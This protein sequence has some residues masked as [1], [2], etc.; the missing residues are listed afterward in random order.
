[1]ALLSSTKKKIAFILLLPF[2]ACLGLI[3]TLLSPVGTYVFQWLANNYVEELTIE[4]ISGSVLSGLSVEGIRYTGTPELSLAKAEIAINWQSTHLKQVTLSNIVLKQGEIRLPASTDTIETNEVEQP[5]REQA[6]FTSPVPIEIESIAVS[7]FSVVQPTVRIEVGQFNTS[8]YFDE[9]L[10]VSNTSLNNLTI[11]SSAKPEQ[12]P[13]FEKLEYTAPELPDMFIPIHATIEGLN[14]SAIT[15]RTV[16]STQIINQLRAATLQVEGSKVSWDSLE[17]KHD[18]AQLTTTGNIRLAD[19]YPLEVKLNAEAYLKDN[20]EQQLKLITGGSLSELKLDAQLSGLVTGTANL[21]VNVL[22]DALPIE[23]KINWPEQRV[24]YQQ[25]VSLKPGELMIYGDMSNYQ[26]RVDSALKVDKLDEVVFIADL[27]LAGSELTVKQLDAKLLGGEIITSANVN[28]AGGP[29]AIGQ[30]TIR[31]IGVSTFAPQLSSANIP[32]ASWDYKITQH[33]DTLLLELVNIVGNV[34]IEEQKIQLEG[35]VAYDQL[36]ERLSTQLRINQPNSPNIL[37]LEATVK[38]QQTLNV[39]ATIDVPQMER[40][41]PDITGTVTGKININGDWQNPAFDANVQASKIEISE[42]LSSFLHQQGEYNGEVVLQGDLRRHSLTM[43]ANMNG[44]RI[45]LAANGGL[46]NNIYQGEIERSEIIALNTRWILPSPAKLSVNTQT[47]DTLLSKHCWQLANLDGVEESSSNDNNA[48]LC[49]EESTYQ[50]DSANW[51]VTANNLPIGEWA[52]ASIDTITEVSNSAHLSFAHQG[53]F[54]AS[55]VLSASLELN[56]AKSTWTLGQTNPIPVHIKQLDLTG[57]LNEQIISVE[58]QLLGDNIGAM[59]LAFSAN[60]RA[61]LEKDI[62][63]NI[64]IDNLDLKPL[65][66]FSPSVHKLEGL[67]NGDITVSGLGKK[68]EV[69]GRLALSQGVVSVEQSPV[70]LSNWEQTFTLSGQKAMIDGSFL[71]GEGR[72][73]LGG[74]LSWQDS[75]FANFT[76]R[77]SDIALQHD[78]SVVRVSPSLM[79]KITPEDVEVSGDINIPYAR[80]K[81]KDVPKSA[82]TPSKDVRIIDEEQSDDPVQN[83]NFDININIDPDKTKNVKLDAF[84]LTASLNGGLNVQSAPSLVAFGDLS[85]VDGRYKAYGQNLL[86]R[87]G[88]V[89][90]NGPPSRPFLFVEAIRD[91]ELTE[92]GVIAG[93]RIDGAV[94]AP[95]VA[96]FSEPPMEQAQNLLYLI[97][98]KG[99]LSGGDSDPNYGAMLLGL[100]LSQSGKVTNSIGKSLGIED[101]SL[102]TSGQGSDSQ[103]SLSGNITKDLSVRFGVGLSNGQEAAIRYR[104]LP[105]LYLQAVRQF[106]ESVNLID[107]FYEFSLGDPAKKPVPPKEK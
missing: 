24:D 21:N 89:Q 80:I 40:F 39:N 37:S 11:Y 93:V 65:S 97:N 9:R 104:I 33:S 61:F 29:S 18:K 28:F 63:A 46:S 50:N 59:N 81:I 74:E 69:N 70:S 106:T 26:L 2:I 49:I 88:E 90:F 98:G 86:I 3:I 66:Y 58:A 51:A 19:V 27:R 100:G 67:I 14:V 8:I 38:K 54:D 87:S 107:L 22:R 85:V 103:I 55:K 102:T 78:Q 105:N 43:F 71:L 82:V 36:N 68:P 53:Q 83:I 7:A 77:A 17:I 72:G 101:L 79:A 6:L 23:G 75:P 4:N 92:D 15:Y 76:V 45:N 34:N 48:S 31:S 96:L 16:E 25:I 42:S 5:A 64:K 73:Q 47:Q 62:S 56:M 95:S 91:P 20:A 44:N 94:S 12:R 41:L 52:Q 13:P 10:L 1:M 57:K 30:T 99:N 32:N 35:D 84:G 60:Q